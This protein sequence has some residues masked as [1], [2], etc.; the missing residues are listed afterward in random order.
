MSNPFCLAQL[1]DICL[2]Q[3]LGT[4]SPPCC[5]HFYVIEECCLPI[6]CCL[7]GHEWLFLFS[8]YRTKLSL[9]ES[10]RSLIA[11]WSCYSERYL[12][13]NHCWHCLTPRASCCSLCA[14]IGCHSSK[15]TLQIPALY[16]PSGHSAHT[17]RTCVLFAD[18]HPWAALLKS[19]NLSKHCG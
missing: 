13:F 16:S 17:S 5:S 6:A 2:L 19:S 1:I 8:S 10:R 14:T 9:C 7:S 11:S 3:T 15:F 18:V 12:T 4:G